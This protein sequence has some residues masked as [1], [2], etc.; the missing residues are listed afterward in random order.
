MNKTEIINNY[1]YYGYLP[2][3]QFPAWLNDGLKLSEDFDYSVKGA[4]QVFDKIF[5]DLIAKYPNKKHIVPLSGGWDSRAILGALLERVDKS[6][7]ETVTFGVPGQL[8]YD[9]GIKVAKWAG[10]KYL[11]I[12]LKKTE[13]TWE[14]ILDSVKE[15]PW[16][17]VPDGMFNSISRNTFSNKA[18]IIWSG[19]LGG[20]LT[21]SQL[22]ETTKKDV[23]INA[24]ITKQQRVRKFNLL[25]PSLQL[26]EVITNASPNYIEW[27]DFLNLGIKQANC[28]API[29]L[30]ISNLT[31]FKQSISLER[32]G[33][34][35]IA[36]FLNE[37]FMDYWLLAPRE[38]RRNQKLY[39]NML[40]YKYP[41][42][43]ALPSKYSLGMPAKSGI[44]YN[45]KRYKNGVIRR[46]QKKA[47]WL[48]I[49]STAHLNYLDYDT[50]FRERNDYKETLNIALDF[51]KQ[52]DITPWL[53]L[54]QLRTD[55]MK[56]KKEY[57]NVFC[58]LIGLAANLS[59][60]LK[61][62]Q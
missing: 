52:T 5:D 57:G 27:D 50:M 14:N 48:G 24:F 32:N 43:F 61:H 11:A 10:V 44:R 38:L 46:I 60:N 62:K 55:H 15:S 58:V 51:L 7:I 22:N 54:D 39:I 30:P 13:F 18:D 59:M 33:A 6:Q 36:P 42:L 8:D 53:N 12:N 20:S 28:I 37:R 26:K 31:S 21:G 23:C 1:L 16:T 29:V 45:Y 41:E 49:R 34:I 3:K 9:I 40:N 17:Y 47:P 56:N 2:P 35:V 25:D 4:T 19:F